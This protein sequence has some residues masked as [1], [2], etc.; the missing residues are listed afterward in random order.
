M[1]FV[2]LQ[3]VA[4]PLHMAA[5]RTNINELQEQLT[6]LGADPNKRDKVCMH[7]TCTLW[8]TQPDCA[9]CVSRQ[10]SVWSGPPTMFSMVQTHNIQINDKRVRCQMHFLCLV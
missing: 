7:D 8:H 5:W 1:L 4:H 3:K 10:C 9:P 6:K 2:A